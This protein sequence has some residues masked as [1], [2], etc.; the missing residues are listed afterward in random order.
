MAVQ[1]IIPGSKRKL[2]RRSDGT[3]YWIN[4]DFGASVP[5]DESV[6]IR[7]DGQIVMGKGWAGPPVN[8]A[9]IIA[10]TAKEPQAP[11]RA[12]I[13]EKNVPHAEC[14]S[15]GDKYAKYNRLWTVT[16]RIGDT[17]ELSE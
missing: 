16:N 1:P 10:E 2:V 14:Y 13:I 12:R 8:A 15:I 17:L 5:E 9:Q 3:V 4:G 7:P 6:E 11:S